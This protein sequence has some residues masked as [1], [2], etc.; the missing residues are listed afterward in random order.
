M[1]IVKNKRMLEHNIFGISG[2]RK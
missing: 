2:L 1:V